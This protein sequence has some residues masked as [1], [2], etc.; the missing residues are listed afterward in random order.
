MSRKKVFRNIG[1]IA[2]L[3]VW[4]FW[5]GG[6]FNVAWNRD[7]SMS[8]KA[9]L[10]MGGIALIVVL[11][12]MGLVVQKV[13]KKNGS[14]DSSKIALIV[15]S[16]LTALFILLAWIKY[17]SVQQ[18]KF[19]EELEPHFIS[20]Y[21]EKAENQNVEIANLKEELSLM[22]SYIKFELKSHPDLNTLMNLKTEEELF[23]KNALIPTLSIQYLEWQEKI[24]NTKHQD[25]YLFFKLH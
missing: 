6:N 7:Y 10:I 3:T 25:L 22:F 18:T 16:V 21:M 24:G 8:Y 19:M 20:F 4:S 13:A 17:D 2:L 23:E 1:W 9:S 14:T 15:V 5:A 12:V 11:L